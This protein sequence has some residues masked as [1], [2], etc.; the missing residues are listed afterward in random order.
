M[1]VFDIGMRVRF[2]GLTRRTGM[3]FRGPA[4]WAEWS[5]FP[6]YSDEEAANWLRAAIEVA[7]HG[8]PGPFRDQ[9]P[10]NGIVPALPPDEA[11]RRAVE[12]GCRTI[13]IKVAG[14][15]S[16]DD[17]IA[18]VRAVR[19]ALPDVQLRMDANGGW[20]VDEASRAIRELAPLGLEYVEQ[21]CAAVEDL[22][23]LRSLGLGV[24]I[25]ADESIRRADDPYRVV[26]LDAADGIVLKAQ[27]LG[28]VRR[29]LALAKEIKLPVVVSSAVETS[30]GLAAGVALAAALP[31]LPW[32]CGLETIRLLDGD[33]VDEPLMPVDGWLTPPIVGQEPVHADR[34]LADDETTRWWQDRFDRVSKLV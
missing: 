14:E 34:H 19:D 29:C 30:I 5:P 7:E 24:P 1:I 33:V 6:E 27:P 2:R 4:G 13:K 20:T 12:T 31:E 21:P 9:V 28:G 15:T 16:L 11:A 25:V 32:A 18:R 22:A 26:E 3:L 10:V 17:D 8:Y 23:R